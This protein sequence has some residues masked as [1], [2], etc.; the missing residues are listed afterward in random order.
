MATSGSV[1]FSVSRDEIITTALQDIGKL[2]RN[3]SPSQSDLTLCSRKLNMIV[4]QW[5]G[6]T[7]FSPG[8]KMWTRKRGTLFLQKNQYKYSLGATGDHATTSFVEAS[9]EVAASATDSTID[10]SSISGMLSAD[11]IGIVLDSGSVHWTTING[12]PA[13]N[14]VTL[15]DAMPSSS[16]VGR[17]VWTYTTKIDKPLEILLAYMR[18]ASGDDSPLSPI[19]LDEYEAIPDKDALGDPVE[20]YYEKQLSNGDVYFDSAIDDV[21]NTFKFVFLRPIEDFDSQ[22]DTPDFPQEYYRL[23]S[24]QL[25]ID[26]SPSFKVSVTPE[27]QALRDEALTIAQ[28]LDPETSEAYFQPGV[29]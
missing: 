9:L 21:T 13:G 23:L 12:A 3:Q 24:Y 28:Q 18:D 2:A 1:D 7:D 10:I 8:F 25:A 6:R 26:I 14:T 11:N 27:L 15:T 17:T 4:K 20:Y 16:A 22:D 5:Q 29:D 19:T